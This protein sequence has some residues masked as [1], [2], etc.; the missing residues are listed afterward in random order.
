LNYLDGDLHGH[1]ASDHLEV[2]EPT[3]GA[4]GLFIDDFVK[5]AA[6]VSNID[7]LRADERQEKEKGLPLGVLLLFSHKSDQF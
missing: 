7:N 6:D 4:L 3:Q 2:V 5:I 1:P